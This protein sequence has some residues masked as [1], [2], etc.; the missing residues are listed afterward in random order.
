MKDSALEVQRR[1]AAWVV[2]LAVNARR[3][4]RGAI[5]VETAIITALLGAIA[6]G[7][8]GFIGTRVGLW[9]NAIPSP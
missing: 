9:Q 1:L 4:D 2:A 5:S 6:V 3:D 8:A 7:F